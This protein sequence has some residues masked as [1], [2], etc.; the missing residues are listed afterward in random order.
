[1][2]RIHGHPYSTFVRRVH[3]ALVEKNIPHEK[4]VVDMQAGEHRKPEYRKRNPYGRV[5]ALEEDGFMLY[6]SSAILNYLEATHPTPALVPADVRGRALVDMH[7]K[8]CDLQMTRQTGTIIF[9]KRFLPKDRWIEADM[10]KAREEI[11]KHLAILESD[12]GGAEYLVGGRYSLADIAY[13]PFL[14]FLPLMEITPPPGIA[15]WREHLMA[16]PSSVATK[17]AQ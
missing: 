3:I 2:I 13:I 14:E 17:P 16:R 4:I 5:P 6:E 8:L 11:E 7:M 12:L 1:M 9:P 15:A 10:A